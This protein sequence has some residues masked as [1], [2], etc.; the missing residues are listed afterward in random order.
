MLKRLINLRILLTLSLFVFAVGAVSYEL[1]VSAA[2]HSITRISLNPPT[3]NLL[4]HNQRVNISFSYSTTQRGGVRIFAR[5]FVGNSPAPAYAASP[6][7][8]LRT[9]SGTGTQYFTITAGD[10][11]VDR[12]RFQMYNADTTTVI[13]EA[14]IPVS[15]EFRAP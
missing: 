4:V 6:S 14:F 9:G 15:Y 1:N 3:P 2:G 8:I 12:I 7:G 5:P 13:Y 11:T 10:V